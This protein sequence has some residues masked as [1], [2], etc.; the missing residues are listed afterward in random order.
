MALTTG[1]ALAL[2]AAAAA[3]QYYN[4][5]Q[6]AKRQDREAAAGIRTQAGIQRRADARVNEEVERL[7]SS[8]AEDERATRTNEFMQQLRTARGTTERGLEGV[9]LGDAF[10]AAAAGARSDL[11]RQGETTAGQLAT[12]DA[13]GLQRQGE[14]FGFG[15][16]A[17][18][19]G[20]ISRES[21]GQQFLTDL[22]TRAIRRNPLIDAGS[23]FL[24]GVAGGLGAG[25]GA[26]GSAA[27]SSIG[28]GASGIGAGIYG[29]LSGNQLAAA[30]RG[31]P[32]GS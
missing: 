18:D 20:L 9:G 27:A 3:G 32:G 14:G 15:N 29:S 4:T 8:T 22:R 21:G 1:T 12:I 25:A 10:Q 13:A 11:Q 31:I 7:E 26:A 30:M 28:S 16:L 23:A 5:Q 6:T 24:G 17:T 2:A 19:L